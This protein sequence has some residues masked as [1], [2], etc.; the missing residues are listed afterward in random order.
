MQQKFCRE[1]GGEIPYHFVVFGDSIDVPLAGYRNPV[2]RPLQLTLEISEVLI[3]LKIG[4][5]LRDGN[6]SA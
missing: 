2:F 6:E 5:I 1:V 3:G 4:I